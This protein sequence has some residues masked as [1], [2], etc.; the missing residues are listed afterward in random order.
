MVAAPT[1]NGARGQS[2]IDAGCY[3]AEAAGIF[4]MEP[5]RVRGP[6]PGAARRISAWL[7]RSSPRSGSR[8]ADGFQPFPPLP[9]PGSRESDTGRVPDGQAA[10][11][12]GISARIGLAIMI[13]VVSTPRALLDDLRAVGTEVNDVWALV[14]TRDRYPN[15]IPVLM[16]W[17]AHLEERGVAGHE[18]P[19]LREGIVRS[20][21]VREA[22]PV[23]A[24][25]LIDEFRAAADRGDSLGWEIG[26][27]LGIV[28]DDSCFAAIAELAREPSYG[29]ARQML[30]MEAL[31]RMKNPEATTVLLGLLND[32]DVN[33]H[34]I[35]GL[36]KR[37][38]ERAR[39]AFE[40]FLDDERA[41]VRKQAKKGLARLDP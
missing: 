7:N 32:A 39:P 6:V 27:A 29:I 19:K 36:A 5:A 3:P 24:P 17:L 4:S 26:N 40:R 22:R 1:A 14:N 11:S 16:D 21:T 12:P 34:A 38:D 10:H 41:W 35:A 28:A 25:L 18:L 8:Y 31:G 20:L 23:A 30:A 9:S 37:R 13:T 2:D 33:G 15:A